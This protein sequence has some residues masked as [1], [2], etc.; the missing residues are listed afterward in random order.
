MRI[1]MLRRSLSRLPVTKHSHEILIANTFPRFFT[2]TILAA[3][4]WHTSLAFGTCPAHS[5]PALAWLVAE[6]IGGIAT[7]P[8]FGLVTKVAF[9]AVVTFAFHRFATV[10]VIRAAWQLDANVAVRARPARMAAKNV[11]S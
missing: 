3:R 9:V 5:A 7:L 10:A 4:V 6:A 8:T 1:R 11:I 2:V